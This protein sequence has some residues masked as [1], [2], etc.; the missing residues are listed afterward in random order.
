M[1]KGWR[2]RGGRSCGSSEAAHGAC[3]HASVTSS[4]RRRLQQRL[5][6]LNLA[7]LM[8]NSRRRYKHYIIV[9]SNG[10]GA[11]QVPKAKAAIEYNR[12][13]YYSSSPPF[14]SC[15]TVNSPIWSGKIALLSEQLHG[16]TTKTYIRMLLELF[17]CLPVEEADLRFVLCRKA[18][19]Q[20]FWMR[21]IDGRKPHPNPDQPESS[22][23]L[24]ISIRRD[25]C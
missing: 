5:C 15:L 24:R 22:N 19:Q 3:R 4:T 7:E 1:C 25:P 23:R 9:H 14:N 12:Q 13:E 2:G 16:G 21:D 18:V 17:V 10:Y 6:S 11:T 8:E 20:Y